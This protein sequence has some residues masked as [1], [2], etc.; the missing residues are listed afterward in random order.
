MSDPHDT[1]LLE[2]A[3]PYAL[4]ALTEGERGAVEH[5]L[6]TADPAV[7]EGFRD[8]VRDIRETVAAMT[9]VDAIPAPA[10]LEGALQ[11]ALDTGAPRLTMLRRARRRSLWWVAA[12]VML[13]AISITAG[14]ALLRAPAPDHGITAQQI[15]TQA[16]ARITTLPVTGGGTAT[17]SASAELDAAAVSFAAVAAAPTGHTYQLWLLPAD[18]RPRSAAVLDALPAEADPVVV[19]LDSAEGLALSVEPA[20][21]SPQPSTEPVVAVPLR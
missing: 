19:P 20:G 14:A 3:Y 11:R 7:A 5:A 1:D 2:L 9:V 21:G 8:M 15:R 18:G 17:V 6:D 10:H 16:D 12:A 4:D 13:V